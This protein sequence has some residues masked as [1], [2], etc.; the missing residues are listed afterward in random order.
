[1]LAPQDAIPITS[2]PG[3]SNYFN[4]TVCRARMKGFIILDYARRFAEA[5][6]GRP[7]RCRTARSRTPI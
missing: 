7:P 2:Q 1:M 3:P 6:E 5:S 4:L